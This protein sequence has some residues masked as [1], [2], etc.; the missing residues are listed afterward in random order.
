MGQWW[1][2]QAPRPRLYVKCRRAVADDGRGGHGGAERA[3]RRVKV[4]GLRSAGPC[5]CGADVRAGP[6]AGC[7]Q[8]GRRVVC[9]ACL[10]LPA[11]DVPATAISAA[12]P[13]TATVTVTAET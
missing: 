13:T 10:D 2:P 7:D 9:P 8:A 11:H 4:R 6:R 1:S 3:E 12:P 5:G